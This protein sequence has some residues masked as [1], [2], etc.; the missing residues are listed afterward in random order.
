[1]VMSGAF[2]RPAASEGTKETTLERPTKASS[3][4]NM[5]DADL[6]ILTKDNVEFYVHRVI[7]CIASP[8]FK[9]M[10]SLPQPPEA[11]L[12]PSVDVSEDSQTMET[13]LRII[14]PVA[15]PEIRSLRHLREVLA[16][17][18]KYDV[19]VVIAASRKALSQQAFIEADPLQV[20][21]LACTLG[22]EA[23]AKV[24]AKAAVVQNR[25]SGAT[26][27]DLEEITAGGYFR[28]SQLNRTR[29]TKTGPLCF[30]EG[31][32]GERVSVDFTE[33]GPLCR[34]SQ[35]LTTAWTASRSP[36]MTESPPPAPQ[37]RDLF[38]DISL[39]PDIIL[40]SCDACSFSAH[41][42]VIAMASPAM[43]STL[44]D[45]YCHISSDD[46]DLPT[47]ELPEKALVLEELLRLCYPLQ[48]RDIAA[49]DTQ[50]F[51]DIL[52]ASRTYKL[53]KVE[54]MLQA[55]WSKIA[56]RE[57]LRFYFAAVRFGWKH[58]A[59]FC[60]QELIRRTDDIA[61][62]QTQYIPEMEDIEC[63]P[64]LYLLSYIEECRKV[65]SSIAEGLIMFLRKV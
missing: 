10:L 59:L 30:C 50:Q 9:T 42:S 11:V 57:P 19:P 46:G 38:M 20:F 21:A 61:S 39:P 13:F 14:Y 28:L 34:P 25:V 47:Y 22:M 53:A 41:Q 43:W 3:P 37:R 62:I 8:I 55:Q 32:K 40:K 36:S 29:T 31:S 23:E 16:A 6:V 60:A 24:A 64:Y 5:D 49:Y 54:S 45:S 58:E 56:K 12:T 2:D 4:F 1:M 26:C 35:L 15:D 18:M 7:L 52:S 65:V 48:F 51:L 17:G 33:I 44:N 63:L 27:A